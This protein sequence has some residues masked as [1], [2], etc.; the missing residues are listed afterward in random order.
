MSSQPGM[1]VFERILSMG[2]LFSPTDNRRADV[3][4]LAADHAKEVAAAVA[5]ERERCARV[6]E[7]YE[8][9]CESCPRGV[10][11]AIRAREP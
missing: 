10:A 4:E 3:R 9:H 11:A 5:A 6:A 7:S 1:S 2:W 8:P